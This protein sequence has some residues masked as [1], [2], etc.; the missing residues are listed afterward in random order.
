MRRLE[1]LVPSS[2]MV[3][4]ELVECFQEGVAGFVGICEAVA[5]AGYFNDLKRG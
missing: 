2:A 5:E 1:R 4:F 3:Y